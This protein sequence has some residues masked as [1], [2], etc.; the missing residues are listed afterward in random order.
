[1]TARA[2]PVWR[3]AVSSPGS[4]G[5]LG[6]KPSTTYEFSKHPGARL[7]FSNLFPF[8]STS[9][10]FTISG[11][12]LLAFNF[13]LLPLCKSSH[14]FLTPLPPLCLKPVSDLAWFAATVLA[15]FQVNS[16]SIY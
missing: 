15:E 10:S 1:M 16:E 12:A 11:P 13:S 5:G 4:E 9:C 7:H 2:T 3:V 14:F 6:R 8:I